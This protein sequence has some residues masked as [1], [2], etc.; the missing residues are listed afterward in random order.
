MFDVRVFILTLV[1]KI[2]QLVLTQTNAIIA[3]SSKRILHQQHF[4]R[5]YFKSSKVINTFLPFIISKVCHWENRLFRGMEFSD[6][7][8]FSFVF[9]FLF[10]SKL[11]DTAAFDRSVIFSIDVIHAIYHQNW[12]EILAHLDNE[13]ASLQ[14]T[15]HSYIASNKEV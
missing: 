9:F 2:D 15:W 6:L 3:V 13:W 4:C 8:F 14:V 10:Y 11:L 12:M 7:E 5:K 1:T